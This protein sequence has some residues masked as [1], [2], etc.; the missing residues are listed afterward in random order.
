MGL[1]EFN[2]LPQGDAKRALGECCVSERWVAGV[3]AGRPYAEP[4]DLREGAARI[5]NTLEERDWLEAFEGHPKIGDVNSLKAKYAS[6]GHVAAAEQAGAATASDAV[7]ERL[8]QGNRAY[9]ARFGFI[10]IVYATGKSAEEMCAL[11]EER[12]GNE[13]TTELRIAAAE[14][15]KILL[16]RLEKLL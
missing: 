11:L 10:F 13:R 3:E 15:L 2:A 8:A 14:Q 12:L 16:L 1:A 6:T 4:D 7:L 5:W 9:E